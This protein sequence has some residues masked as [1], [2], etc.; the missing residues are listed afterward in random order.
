LAYKAKDIEGGL[1]KRTPNG[2]VGSLFGKG[3]PGGDGRL[4][5]K[6]GAGKGKQK[7]KALSSQRKGGEGQKFSPSKLSREVRRRPWLLDAMGSPV[8]EGGGARPADM[9]RVPDRRSGRRGTKVTGSSEQ[10]TT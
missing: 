5:K 3:T 8:H 9:V 10:K 1:S 6:N 2:V 7:R 4:G